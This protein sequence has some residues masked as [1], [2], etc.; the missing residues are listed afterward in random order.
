MDA[1][2]KIKLIYYRGNN[3]GDVLSKF[4]VENV[5][6]CQVQNKNT[7]NSSIFWQLKTFI[8]CL[9]YRD[10]NF[11]KEVTF[12]YER[13]LLAI[14]SILSKGNSQSI[15]W[16]SGFMFKNEK[17]HGG[18]TYAVRGLFS[19]NMLKEQGFSGCNTFGDPAY[20]L[21]LF[22]APS[23][24]KKYNISIIPHFSEYDYFQKTYSNQYHIIN[25]NETN[26]HKV[27]EEITASEKVLSTSL[28]GIIVSHAYHIPALWIKN[29]YI[30]T[31][32]LK[33]Y[34]YFS[35]VN[36]GVYSGFENVDNILKSKETI[37][38]FLQEENEYALPHKD[39]KIV[40]EELLNVA[41]FPKRKELDVLTNK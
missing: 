28:H 12:F 13:P 21:P 26:I 9:I 11:F 38:K 40:Q 32:G 17:F 39:V 41:P 30:E 3:F 37:E 33:F 35:S 7:Y 19:N 2:K 6:G 5:S 27:V 8:K 25:L 1:K 18:K 34:D 20:L 31:D 10:F 14:G 36:I 22:I 16:G 29:G 15:V 4:I 23:K 24:H